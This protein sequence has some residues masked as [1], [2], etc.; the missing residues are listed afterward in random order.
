MPRNRHSSC[1]WWARWNNIGNA[2]GTLNCGSLSLIYTW[3]QIDDF[4]SNFPSALSRATALDNKVISDVTDVAS[5]TSLTV[6]A[7]KNLVILGLRQAIG[8]LE[9]TLSKFANGTFAGMEDARI[10]MKDVGSSRYVGQSLFFLLL[11]KKYRDRRT[12]PVEI[13]YASFPA[14]LYLNGSLAGVLLEPL[15]EFQ[16]SASPSLKECAPPDLGA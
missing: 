3:I 5:K 15:F 2:V 6:T 1:L 9:F 13:V 14:F 16:S 10:F 12:N 7:L 4:L 8:S 11:L